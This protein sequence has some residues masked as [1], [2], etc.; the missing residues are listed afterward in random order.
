MRFVYGVYFPPPKLEV[1]LRGDTSSTILHPF[2]IHFGHLCGSQF[3][4]EEHGQYF[5]LSIQAGHLLL[6]QEALK[7]MQEKGDP[8][9][10]AQAHFYMGFAYTYARSVVLGNRLLKRAVEVIRRNNI[11]FVP[12]STGDLAEHNLVSAVVEPLDLMRERVTLLSGVVFIGIIFY[13][14]GQPA[15]VLGFTFEDDYKSAMPVS[16]GCFLAV[17]FS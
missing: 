11:R 10:Y 16:T 3:Y 2:F 5:L 1:F 9:T 17:I 14:V 8:F 13:L 15:L 4:Q 7:T 6:S 12:M